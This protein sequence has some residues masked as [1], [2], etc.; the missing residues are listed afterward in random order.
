MTFSG[1]QNIPYHG[2]LQPLDVAAARTRDGWICLA[3]PLAPEGRLGWEE[4]PGFSKLRHQSWLWRRHGALAVACRR[5]NPRPVLIREFSSIPLLLWAPRF[6]SMRRRLYFL[7]NHNLQWA[8]SE[9]AER[10][11]WRMLQRMGFRMVFFETR[12]LP[13]P[14]SYGLAHSRHGTIP[15]PMAARAAATAS[16]RAIPGSLPLVGVAGHARAEKDQAALVE[17]LIAAGRGKWRVAVGAS[18]PAAYPSSLREAGVSVRAT[19][20]A[21][22]YESF[23]RDCDA[24][25]IAPRECRYRYRPSGVLAD[26]LSVG[27]PGVAPDF[28]LFRSQLSVPCDVGEVFSRPE[29]LSGAVERALSRRVAG[30]YDFEKYRAARS[31]EAIARALDDL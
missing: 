10:L 27:T 26:A 18:N 28:P 4:R 14:T 25:V 2:A 9:S 3:N 20:S 1:P 19:M 17:T 11:A 7:V 6:L 5:T 12:D 16:R 22:E 31:P 13:L 8:V 24:I 30:E 29:D 21:A 23:L 15:F